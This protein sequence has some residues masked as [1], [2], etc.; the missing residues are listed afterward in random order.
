MIAD[1]DGYTVE[2]FRKILALRK[3]FSEGGK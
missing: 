3:S 1:V 2:G